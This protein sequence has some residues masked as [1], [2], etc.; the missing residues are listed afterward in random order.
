M[1]EIRL[2]L[3]SYL[4]QRGLNPDDLVEAVGTAIDPATV[5]QLVQKED[6]LEQIN[7]SVL[8]AVMQ[9]L[10]KLMGFTV[11]IGEVMQFVP[12]LSPEEMNP[13][14]NTW[15][16]LDVYGEI[17]PYNWGDEDPLTIGKPVRYIPGVGIVIEDGDEQGRT[18]Q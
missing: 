7:L 12:D 15:Y 5:H 4:K 13:E 17:P 18:V 11:G 6:E 8:A 1:S 10:K 14:T 16:E 2:R 9:A 3:A